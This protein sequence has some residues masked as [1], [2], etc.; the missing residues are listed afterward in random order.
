M[1]SAPRSAKRPR[2]RSFRRI[3]A[4]ALVVG[5]GGS[6]LAADASAADTGP[7]GSRTAPA[8]TVAAP[9]TLRQ[10]SSGAAVVSL[11][12][13]L[14]G[15]RY[16]VGPFDGDFGSQT[17]H[18][19][20]AF[21]KVNNLPRDG[22][23]GPT[24]WAAL[25]KPLTPRPRYAHAG[26]SVEVRLDKQVLFLVRDSEVVRILDASTGKASTPTPAGNFTVLRHIDGWRQSHLGLMWR[27]N[28]F[29]GGYAIHGYSSVP[30]YPASHGCVRIP[31]PSMD[32]LWP[33]LSIGMPVHIYRR[34]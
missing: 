31:M 20:V 11:Q 29:Y 17:F 6:L 24:T 7:A 10:G 18:A 32:R 3:A 14:H 27:P 15:L 4:L 26:Y 23:V 2:R 34:S 30:N 12:R 8:A 13:R 25:A 21:Q 5:L 16:D 22:V 1:F 9:P 33:R 19:V 28:Y